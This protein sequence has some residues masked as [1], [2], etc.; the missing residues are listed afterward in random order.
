MS[1]FT[2]GLEVEIRR[3]DFEYADL[4]NDFE[5][6]KDLNKQLSIRYQDFVDSLP[7]VLEID[8]LIDLYKIDKKNQTDS[9]II[10]GLD[11]RLF[12]LMRFRG[13][14]VLLEKDNHNKKPIKYEELFTT[15]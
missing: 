14:V 8:L 9:M 13:A 10:K 15:K 4:M 1:D 3:E 2:D 11:K 6:V 7:N 5:F 12:Q